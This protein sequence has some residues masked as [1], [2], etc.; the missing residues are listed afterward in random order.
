[1]DDLGLAAIAIRALAGIVD[2]MLAV[3][4]SLLVVRG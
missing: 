4:A 3:A 1:V 2:Q